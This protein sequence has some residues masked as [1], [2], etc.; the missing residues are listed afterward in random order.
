MEKRG[1]SLRK[2]DPEKYAR[3]KSEV[4]APYRGLRKFVYGA[5]AVSGAIGGFVFLTQ[6]LAGQDVGE[7]LPNFALQAGVVALMIWLFR[8]EGRRS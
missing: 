1:D 6:M 3:L 5:F 7:A 8:L 4:A 2:S